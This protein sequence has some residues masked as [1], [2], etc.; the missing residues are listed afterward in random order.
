MRSV[1]SGDRSFASL[2]F[3]VFAMSQSD[4]VEHVSGI[5]TY[6][7]PTAMSREIGRIMVRWAYFEHGVQEMNWGVANLPQSVGRIAMREPRVTDR[8]EMLAD[9][10][11]L[12]GATMDWDLYK[13]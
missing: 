12:R 3:G 13:S 10:I 6:Q 8:L 11:R 5:A 7:L 4:Q 9:L 1:S 2:L